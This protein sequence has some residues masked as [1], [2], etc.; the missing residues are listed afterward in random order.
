MSL[1]D[2]DVCRRCRRGPI[3]HAAD[4]CADYPNCVPPQPPAP[5]GGKWSV[6]FD[7]PSR[8]IILGPNYVMLSVSQ[9]DG[10]S[11]RWGSY[12]EEE[13]H[14]KTFCDA[15]NALASADGGGE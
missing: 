8:P 7:G 5:V 13:T 6:G 9:F 12:D 1:F 3:P 14:C 4:Y 2:L 10:R 11:G 15:M